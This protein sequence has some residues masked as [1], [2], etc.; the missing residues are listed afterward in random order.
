MKLLLDTHIFLWFVAGSSNLSNSARLLIEDVTNDKFISAAS[1]REIAIKV[2][3]SKLIL[4]DTFENSVL[5]QI[6]A[7]GFIILPI[8]NEHLSTLVK[9]PFYHRD[10]FDRLIISQALFEGFDIVSIDTEFDSYKIQRL[11]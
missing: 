4:T 6:G 7:N 10:P 3:L 1:L 2:S 9:L 8:K 5:N 11:W